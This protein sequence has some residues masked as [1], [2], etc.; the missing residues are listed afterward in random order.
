MCAFV[1]FCRVGVYIQNGVNGES[2]FHRFHSTSLFFPFPFITFSSPLTPSLPTS[3][4]LT[5]SHATQTRVHAS[6]VRALPLR[7]SSHSIVLRA[8]LGCTSRLSMTN[9]L[10]VTR[11][12]EHAHERK[13]THAHART[14]THTH[15]HTSSL[16][17][18]FVLAS[19]SHMRACAAKAKRTA[20]AAFLSED[21]RARVAVTHTIAYP[22]P[23]AKF[24]NRQPLHYKFLPLRGL[25]NARPRQRTHVY[26]PGATLAIFCRSRCMRKRW[27]NR[28]SRSSARHP[29]TD[30]HKVAA[31]PSMTR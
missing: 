1:C 28:R 30:P 29:S 25:M 3:L 4:T 17:L 16:L 27:R 8:L 22:S 23:C 7:R 12:C 9:S 11:A 13:S 2:P 31:Q 5:H 10:G 26:R 20:N 18:F 21:A 14:H 24:P 15:T 6:H 19:L